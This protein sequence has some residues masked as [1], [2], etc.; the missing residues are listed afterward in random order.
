M[1]SKG[2]IYVQALTDTIIGDD[3]PLFQIRG[4]FW[5]GAKAQ[6][7]IAAG[8]LSYKFTNDTLVV[9]DDA[10]KG[11]PA[12][13][14]M[15]RTP[16]SLS[17]YLAELLKCGF[18]LVKLHNHKVTRKPGSPNEF[19]VEASSDTALE[20][21]L[22]KNSKTRPTVANISQWVSVTG[23][24][25]SERVHVIHHV[26]LNASTNTVETGY[27]GV[28]TKANIELKANELV[29]LTLNTEGN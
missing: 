28:H 13:A 9:P 2:E 24:L 14:N 5:P 27:P 29:C 11:N 20:Q 10:S 1:T 19:D 18:V 25:K 12:L 16:I 3:V 7:L 8:A 6:E 4:R 23:I 17:I 22:P 21:Q 26:S 15:P